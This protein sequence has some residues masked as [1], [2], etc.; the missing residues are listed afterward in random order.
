M[1][2]ELVMLAAFFVQPHPPA[3][4]LLVIVVDVHPDDSR[5]TRE[6]INH[7]GEEGVVAQAGKQP[8]TRDEVRFAT[9]ISQPFSHLPSGVA[10]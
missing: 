4:P 8:F 6:A 9:V 10:N 1:D 3:F 5:D 7:G 2:G